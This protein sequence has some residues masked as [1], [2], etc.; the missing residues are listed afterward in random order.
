M[1]GNR[2]LNLNE[3]VESAEARFLQENSSENAAVKPRNNVMS[4]SK[5]LEE[6]EDK[7]LS[8]RLHKLLDECEKKKH[9]KN[10]K[11]PHQEKIN[12]I[13]CALSHIRGGTL[14]YNNRKIKLNNE[15]EVARGGFKALFDMG[16][17][18]V[19]ALRNDNDG[20]SDTT[21]M[22][23]KNATIYEPERAAKLRKLGLQTQDYECVEVKIEGYAMPAL[24]MTHFKELLNQGK[25]IRG[26]GKN[27][28]F[29]SSMV[30]GH[31]E[32]LENEEYLKLIFKPLI[33]DIAILIS[34]EIDLGP[35][36]LETFVITNKNMKMSKQSTNASNT[37]VNLEQELHFY[38]LDF[39]EK[40][41]FNQRDDMLFN[42]FEKDE[43]D[44]ESEIKFYL[45]SAYSGILHAVKPDELA[46]LNLESLWA[47]DEKLTLSFKKIKKDLLNAILEEAEKIYDIDQNQNQNCNKL[48]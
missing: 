34:N 31:A 47:L 16:E 6:L 41:R 21:V 20:Y 44:Y 43:Y 15:N 2:N 42:M 36:S 27:E 25:Q 8:K 3:K 4:M 23:W 22:Q 17:G 1:S 19:I 46:V 38:L 18:H 10:E 35:D 28:K 11:D 30:F 29:G 12:E 48:K 14:E 37:I 39:F 26:V 40:Q 24:R 13:Q 33:K 7:D 45:R 5:I 9:Q 32:N